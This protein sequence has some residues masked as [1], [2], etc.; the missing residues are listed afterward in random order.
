MQD[1]RRWV[2]AADVLSEVF[3]WPSANLPRMESTYDVEND[4]QLI[5]VR[6]VSLIIPPGFAAIALEFR[7]TAD[8]DPW[9]VTF[10]VDSTEFGGDTGELAKACADC[11]FFNFNTLMSDETTLSGVQVVVGQDGVEP[12]RAFHPQVGMTGN[13]S[14]EKLPQNCAALIRKNTALGGRRNQG[15]MFLPGILDEN[16]VNQV[17]VIASF[18]V[19]AF[20]VA[21]A[22]MLAD[23][24]SGEQA[25]A[26]PVPS[27]MYLLH[28]EG[29]STLPPPTIVTSLT[30]DNV[31]STQRRRLR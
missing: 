3:L 31:I 21:A 26:T 16:E 13:S 12:V 20:Q 8:P 7:H 2:G 1:S 14:G 15:R 22:A 28:S 25:G 30:A 4:S 19:S 27:P 9:Y 18:S 29:G 24:T 11:Y 10:G 5:G 23:L 6:T 17:G